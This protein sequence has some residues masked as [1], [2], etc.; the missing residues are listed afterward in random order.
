MPENIT[1]LRSFLE[2]V[3]YF[4]KHILNLAT[5]AHML[6]ILLQKNTRW[7]WTE[8]H[9]KQFDHVKQLIILCTRKQ[10]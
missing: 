1:Q 10:L 8:E 9:Q 6:H 5:Q 4:S 3:N 2:V 7:N